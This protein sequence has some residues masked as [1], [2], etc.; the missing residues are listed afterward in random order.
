MGQPEKTKRF[1]NTNYDVEKWIQDGYFT[2]E[3]ERKIHVTL[4]RQM[5]FQTPFIFYE[6]KTEKLCFLK[7]IMLVIKKLTNLDFS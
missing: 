3:G 7:F 4:W 1:D 6:Y 2:T 5:A